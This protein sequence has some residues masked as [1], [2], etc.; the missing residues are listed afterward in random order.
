VSKK[1][2]SAPLAAVH[3]TTLGLTEAG[4][5]DKRTMKAFDEMADGW[6]E[7]DIF[8]NYPGVSHDDVAACLA[9]GRDVLTSEKVYPG[10]A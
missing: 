10:A 4:V 6:T 1:Y 9:Y 5:L 7:A 8:R 2:R 3:E